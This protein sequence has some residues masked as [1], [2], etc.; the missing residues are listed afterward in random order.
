MANHTTP[1]T[2]A[3]SV[4]LAPMLDNGS[5]EALIA[6]RAPALTECESSAVPPP[7][8]AA[9]APLRE[10]ACPASRT[11]T[12]APAVGRMKVETE[13]HVESM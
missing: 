1:S 12:T 7:T 5:G 13:S 9:T 4:R 10:S 2:A 8:T 6:S 11:P 3:S